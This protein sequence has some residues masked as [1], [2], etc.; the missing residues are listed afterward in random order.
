MLSSNAS[1]EFTSIGGLGTAYEFGFTLVGSQDRRRSKRDP[2]AATLI[3]ATARGGNYFVE[4]TIARPQE[5]IVRRGASRAPCRGRPFSVPQSA[6]TPALLPALRPAPAGTCTSRWR[7]SSTA[8]TTG[9]G[10]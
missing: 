1:V 5:G 2:Q 6:P 3:D 10:R 4:Y 8:A 7:S 9:C